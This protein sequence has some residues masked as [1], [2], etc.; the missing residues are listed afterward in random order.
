M[1]MPETN[2][3]NRK[4]I[5]EYVESNIK[6]LEEYLKKINWNVFAKVYLIILGY[7]LL[8]VF[9]LMMIIGVANSLVNIIS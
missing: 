3:I 5:P 4:P 8:T 1:K 9:A 7:V 6:K 2:H